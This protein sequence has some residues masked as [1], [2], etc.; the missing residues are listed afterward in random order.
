[1]KIELKFYAN[2]T[3]K[4]IIIDKMQIKYQCC[5]STSFQDWFEVDWYQ[6]E[7][8]NIAYKFIEFYYLDTPFYLDFS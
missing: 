7:G 2:D 5:G 1:M 8:Q 4:K 3:E 6:P